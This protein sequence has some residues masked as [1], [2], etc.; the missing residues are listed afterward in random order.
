MTVEWPAS[1]RS[2]HGTQ[3]KVNGITSQ[4]FPQLDITP[5]LLC[6]LRSRPRPIDTLLADLAGTMTDGKTSVVPGTSTTYTI[7]V[8]NNGPS[9]VTSLTLADTIPAALLN[10]NFAPS[11]GAYD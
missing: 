1:E 3:E 4:L 7:T 11:V 5:R 6:G 9:T 10:S 8:T 2:K